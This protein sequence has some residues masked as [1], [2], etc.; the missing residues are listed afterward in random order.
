MSFR[1]FLPVLLLPLA[2]IGCTRPAPP[3]APTAAR[4][5][6]GTPYE[7]GGSWSYPR[8]DFSLTEAGLAAIIADPRGGRVTA[9]GETYDPALL[10][11]AHRT[12]QL[13]AIIRVTN[14]ENGRELRLR[15]N[16]R[17]PAQVGRLLALSR[18]AAELLGVAA[19]TQIAIT[20]DSDASRALAAAM[21]QPEATTLAVATAPRGVVE[22]ESL[23][24]P[25]GAQAATRLRQARSGPAIAAGPVEAAAQAVPLRLPEELAQ[26]VA[27][28][29]RLFVQGSNFTSRTDAQRQAARMGGA[30]VEPFGPPRRPEYRVRLGPFASVAEADR[31]LELV[32]RS[33]VSEARL[34][35]DY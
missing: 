24:P 18:R 10:T 9:N 25:P 22:S 26:G 4:Y 23:A 13:P 12:L 15:V 6:V 5:T 30:R 35:V 28:P 17:G 7:L 20:V 14:L 21:P 32:R 1:R 29:G 16:D 2:V 3:P 27:R 34:L 31:A 33:G 8:E 19:G 11:A